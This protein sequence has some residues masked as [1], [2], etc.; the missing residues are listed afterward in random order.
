[1]PLCPDHELQH[2]CPRCGADQCE[3]RTPAYWPCIRVKGHE[4]AHEDFNGHRWSSTAQAPTEET[5]PVVEDL[6]GCSVCDPDP[7]RCFLGGF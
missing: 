4:G 3:A 7:C 5:E 2:P 6:E 1:M